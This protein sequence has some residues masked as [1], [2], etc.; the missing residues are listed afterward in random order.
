MIATITPQGITMGDGTSFTITE[1]Q[2]FESPE[3]QVSTYQRGGRHGIVVNR[4]LWR[5]RRLRLTFKLRASTIAAYAELRD[6]FIEAWNLPQADDL[7]TIPFTTIDGKALQVDAQ[8]V[9]AL[10]GGFLPGYVTAG[11]IRVELL[12]PDVNFESQN[13]QTSTVYLPVSSGVPMP[14]ALPI[15][16]ARTGGEATVSNV[17]NGNVFPTLRIYGPVTNPHIKHAGLNI[18]LGLAYTIPSGSYVD[19]DM[20]E[21]TILLNGTGS[22]LSTMSGNF[23][24]LVPGN[25]SITF[26]ADTYDAAAY[27]LITYRNGYT[28]I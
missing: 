16:F 23:W 15:G 8:L 25:N 12:A 14:H 24:Y 11:K 28:G 17:G 13:A 3:V 7:V 22:L 9:N 4:A 18:D 6:Q 21:E 5:G 2:G 19:I 20:K 10:D 1:A 26:S 27:T